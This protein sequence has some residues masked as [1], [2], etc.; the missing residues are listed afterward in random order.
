MQVHVRCWCFYLVGGGSVSIFPD[1]I[2]EFLLVRYYTI[3]GT[4]NCMMEFT[5]IKVFNNAGVHQAL[6]LEINKVCQCWH[7]SGIL[8][9]S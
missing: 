9:L 4:Y 5:K 6:Y 3:L 1:A 7:P 2:I 8:Y